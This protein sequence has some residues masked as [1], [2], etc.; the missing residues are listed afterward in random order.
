MEAI[1]RKVIQA[2]TPS[3]STI[4]R[5]MSRLVDPLWQV[6]KYYSTKLDRN[7]VPRHATKILVL[8]VKGIPTKIQIAEKGY[9]KEVVL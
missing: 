8:D 6:F 9:V 5:S 4:S 7:L 3:P 1:Y 2:E